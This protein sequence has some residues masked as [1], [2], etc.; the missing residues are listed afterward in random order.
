M[1][2]IT[3]VTECSCSI[4]FKKNYKWVFPGEN[5]LIIDK[6]EGTL[7]DY[8]FNQHTMAHRFCPTCGTAIMGKRKGVP[9]S[10]D[11]AIN[12]R[13]LS[14]IDD[15]WALQVNPY[16]GTGRD[17]QYTPPP[18]TGSLPVPSPP[19]ENPKTYTGACHCGLVTVAITVDGPLPDEKTYIQECDC[20]ICSRNGTTLIYPKKSQV[21]IAAKEPL[22]P[23]SFGPKFQSHDFCPVCGVSICIRKLEVAPEKWDKNIGDQEEWY[24]EL[25][26]NLRLFEGVEWASKVGEGQKSINVK[27]GDWKKWGEPYVVPE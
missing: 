22:S 2:E 19:L 15:L 10:M 18:F 6:G 16:D 4:C 26:I 3:S 27:K 12:V 8:Y 21:T 7:K 14:D 5:C 20:S 17:P 9:A 1:P 13:A 11:T 23:Y 25:P 24:G